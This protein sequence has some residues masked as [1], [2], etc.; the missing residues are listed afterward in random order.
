MPQSHL[1][2]KRKQSKLGRKERTWE[3]KWMG[4]G[5]QCVCVCVCVCVCLYVKPDLVLGDGKG[6]K[7]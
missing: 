2:E 5:V 6:L 4:K 1:G 7:P 3:R